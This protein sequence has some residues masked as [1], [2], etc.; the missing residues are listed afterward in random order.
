MLWNLW[1]SAVA[2]RSAVPFSPLRNASEAQILDLEELFDPVFRSFA[3]EAGFLHAAERRDL[4]RDDA[5]VDADDAVLERFGDAPD[6]RDVAA[7]EVRR[8]AELGVVGHRDRVGFGLEPEQR[9]DRSERLL[10]RDGH[11]GRGA[12]DHRGLEE[13]AAARVAVA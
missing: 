11:R 6:A 3:P 5:G 12:G 8:E 7:V 9:R 13:A 2:L 10:A 4:G 1:C